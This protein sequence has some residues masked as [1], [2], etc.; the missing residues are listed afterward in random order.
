MGMMMLTNDDAV[1]CLGT[2][3]RSLNVTGA[4]R[5]SLCTNDDAVERLGTPPS[6]AIVT[7]PQRSSQW[8]NCDAVKN[9]DTIQPLILVMV[10]S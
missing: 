7:G 5:S 10:I 1:E 6:P 2:P 3:V 8:T 9:F 4:Q